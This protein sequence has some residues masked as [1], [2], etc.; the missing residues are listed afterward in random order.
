M[1]KQIGIRLPEEAAQQLTA[2][3]CRDGTTVGKL[4][5]RLVLDSLANAEQ[6]FLR[7]ELGEFKDEMAREFERLR[8]QIQSLKE[9]VALCFTATMC[10]GLKADEREVAAWVEENVLA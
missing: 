8:G 3:A 1:K 6:V 10:D 7:T 9:A 4:A 2:R 5:R